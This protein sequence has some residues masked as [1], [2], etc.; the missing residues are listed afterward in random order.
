MKRTLAVAACAA[1]FA[2]TTAAQQTQTPDTP[3]FRTGVDLLPV[4]VLVVDDQGRPVRGLTPDDFTVSIG[5]QARRVVSAEWVLLT[6]DAVAPS[7]PIPDGYSSNEQDTGGRLIVLAIDQPNIRPGGGRVITDAMLRFIDRL[8]PSDRVAL[9]PLGRGS[10]AISFTKDHARIKAAIPQINGQMQVLVR[11]PLAGVALTLTNAIQ[12]YEGNQ[13]VIDRLVESC[14]LSSGNDRV[15]RGPEVCEQEIKREANQLVQYAKDEKSRTVNALTSLLNNLTVI[16]APKSLVLVSEGF[17]MFDDD[18]DASSQ[19]AELAPLAAAAR[20]TIYGLLLGDQLFDASSQFPVQFRDDIQVRAK[21]FEQLTNTARGALFTVTTTGNAA[22]ERIT[23]ELTGYYLLGVESLPGDRDRGSAPLRV[24]VIR[25]GLTVRARGAAVSPAALLDSS[26]RGLQAAAATALTIPTMVAT[27][28]L[29]AITFNTEGRDRSRVQLVIHADVGRA[30]DTAQDAGIAYVISDKNGAVVDSQAMLEKLVPAPGGFSPLPYSVSAS[31]PP[32]EYVLKLAAIV[33]GKT[34][35]VEH[36][37]VAAVAGAP[38]AGDL[39]LS[40]LIVGGPLTAATSAARPSIDATVRF[41]LV[42]GYLEAYGAIAPRTTVRYEIARDEQSPALAAEDVAGRLVGETRILFSK[43]LPVAGLPPGHYQLRAVI[44]A[45]GDPVTTLARSFD[46]VVPTASGADIPRRAVP[47]DNRAEL[48]LPVD[49]GDLAVPFNVADA[50][51]P[52]TLRSFATMVPVDSRASFDKGIEEL[53]RGDL[54]SA[55]ASFRRAIRPN[56][57]F[58]AATVYLAVTFAAGAHYIDA[59]NA[60]QTALIGHDDLPQIYF[61]LGTTLMR[62]R[63]FA[64]ARAILEEAAARWPADARFARPLAMLYATLG[65]A[66]DAMQMLVRHLTAADAD[67]TALYLGVQWIYQMH[68]NG[69]VLRDHDADVALAR[70]YAD[71]Y[72]R[73]NGPKQP[74]VRE[75]IA[76]LER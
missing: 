4:D 65:K 20:T 33:D 57:D 31:V 32:G 55:E 22:F 7:V 21:G 66:Y 63:E 35:T 13:A 6:S 60:W 34:G 14:P 53:R 54:R 2:V 64:R 37:F 15:N 26:P 25:R 18:L 69:A 30:Y 29:R 36:R 8:T 17:T 46:L 44:R 52:E 41:G 45:D 23:S 39:R 71:Q 70:T 76:F 58:T 48:F 40:D 42:Q 74:L 28:P 3:V 27:L 43:T 72:V 38:T 10:P 67:V 9:V 75:W 47:L 73:A 50:L 24:N 1:C 12:V 11:S 68:L 56:A 16:D 49:T 61:W 59:A 62:A 19:I 5:G 51:A